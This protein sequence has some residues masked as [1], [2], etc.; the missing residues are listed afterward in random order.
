MGNTF[1]G[2]ETKL[3]AKGA[4]RFAPALTAPSLPQSG[5]LSARGPRPARPA[6]RWGRGATPEPGGSFI[7]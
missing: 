6:P 4:K 3:K 1:P 2:I 7:S 5:S